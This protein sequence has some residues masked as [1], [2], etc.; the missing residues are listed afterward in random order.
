[1][2]IAPV[3]ITPGLARL[4]AL[5][6]RITAEGMLRENTPIEDYRAAYGCWVKREDLSCPPPGPAFSKARGVYSHV[7][8]RPEKVIG[9][10]DTAHSQA[11]HAVARACQILG[12]KC[13]NFYPMFKASPEPKAA[14]E[15]AR[16]LGAEIVGL[17]AGRSAILYHAAKKATEARGGYILPNALKLQ[18]SV[19]ETAKEVPHHPFEY[20]LIPIS[21]GTIAAGVIL[22]FNRLGIHPTYI[23]HMGYSRSVAETL[24]YIEKMSGILPGGFKFAVVDEGYAYK[25]RAANG[26]T[27]PWPCNEY[28]DLK[29]LR[30]WI[31]YGRE[32]FKGETLLWNIG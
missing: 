7:K 31:A 30:W 16:S 20:V 4:K 1:M 10:L 9:V 25:D 3:L 23:I 24:R 17:P 28:Y 13:V 5:P 26:D 32:K 11:G 21:S 19:I 14:Q 12:K 15:A 6:S 22:G 27:P 18:E 8:A 29:A 2:P